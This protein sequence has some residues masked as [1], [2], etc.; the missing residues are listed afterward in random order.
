MTMIYGSSILLV[1]LPF[2][3]EFQG[4]GLR[5]EDACRRRA[6]HHGETIVIEAFP[7]RT[8]IDLL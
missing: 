2:S 3:D 8:L 7:S 5:P 4:F 1:V 6:L